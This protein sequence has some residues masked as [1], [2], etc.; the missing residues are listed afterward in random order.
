MAYLSC[1]LSHVWKGTKA[2]RQQGGVRRCNQHMDGGAVDE[3]FVP[4]V[5]LQR[6]DLENVKPFFFFFK[7]NF[8]GVNCQARD[9][10][11]C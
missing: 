10:D 4:I 11:Y 5:T 6:A 3:V 9:T 2:R 7:F 1:L 8:W